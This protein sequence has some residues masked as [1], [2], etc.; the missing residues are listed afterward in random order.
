LNQ[1]KAFKWTVEIVELGAQ[2]K[3]AALKLREVFAA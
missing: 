3:A 1:I 2:I